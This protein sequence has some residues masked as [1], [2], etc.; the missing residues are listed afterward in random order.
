MDMSA[1]NGARRKKEEKMNS[2]TLEIG[3]N[4]A[5]IFGA[6]DGCEMIYNG[7]DSWTQTAPGRSQTVNSPAATK[8]ANE[9][10]NRQSTSMGII[11]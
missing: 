8:A 5:E 2:K 4:Y 1:G 10:I 9:Y 3:K 11:A 6:P 7:G